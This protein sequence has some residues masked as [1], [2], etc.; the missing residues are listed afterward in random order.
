MRRTLRRI[1]LAAGVLLVV[2]LALLPRLVSPLV[3]RRLEAAIERSLDADA[4]VGGIALRWFGPQELRAARLT[5]WGGE[6]I[7]EAT[8]RAETS[9][10]RILLGS[11]DLGE[12]AVR[13]SVVVRRD[14]DG[15][16][17]LAPLPKAGDGRSAGGPAR[18]PAGLAGSVDAEIGVT[19]IDA[20]L[21]RTGTVRAEVS[22][23]GSEVAG[24]VTA[25]ED[26]GSSLEVEGS[27]GGWMG[28]DGLLA[29]ER[30]S[31]T[32][33][34]IAAGGEAS[35]RLALGVEG[36][37]ISLREPASITVGHSALAA[38]LGIDS[39]SPISIAV[40]ALTVSRGAWGLDL[41]GVELRARAEVAGAAASRA[42]TAL[43]ILDL[44]A[45]V[46]VGEGAALLQAGARVAVDGMDGG[47]A[48]IEVASGR[49]LDGRGRPIA[50][51]QGTATA[52]ITGI[53][54]RVLDRFLRPHGLVP[55]EDIGPA[56]SVTAGAGF[57]GTD[58]VDVTGLLR[59]ENLRVE[60]GATL[61]G[62]RLS[63]EGVALDVRVRSVRPALKRHLADRQ[64]E[65]REGGSV[66][67]TVA[68][69]EAELAGLL[70]GDLGGARARLDAKL[71]GSVGTIATSGAVR[72]WR[73]SP[74][75]ISVDATDPAAGIHAAASVQGRVD[76]ELIGRV[77]A[78][79]R[80]FD[81]FDAEGRVGVPGTVRGT[82]LALG[83]DVEVVRTLL[84]EAGSAIPTGLGP[85]LDVTLSAATEAATG[86][87]RTLVDLAIEGGN[88]RAG[89]SVSLVP[90]TIRTDGLWL[91][92]DREVVAALAA[93]AG[94]PR[95]LGVGEASTVRVDVRECSIPLDRHRRPLPLHARV[96]AEAMLAD[97]RVAGREGDGIEVPSLVLALSS[98]PR[99]EPAVSLRGRAS[100]A[101]TTAEVRG[102]I[103]L[104]G[105]ID[106]SRAAH[107]IDLAAV[108][109]AGEVV[110]VGVTPAMVEAVVPLREL[111]GALEGPIEVRLSSEHLDGEEL[112]VELTLESPRSRASASG[113]VRGASYELERARV[114]AAVTPAMA[115]ALAGVELVRSA[116]IVAEVARL[117]VPRGGEGVEGPGEWA[118]RLDSLRIG[119][120]V[121]GGGP[122]LV[123]GLAE[124]LGGAA[125]GVRAYSAEVELSLS[126]EA[127]SALVRAKGELA[128]T[129]GDLGPFTLDATLPLKGGAGRA[130]LVAPALAMARLDSL[131]M[132]DGMLVDAVGESANVRVGASLRGAT[133][134]EA[135]IEVES[136][137]VE[138]V[139]PVGVEV[140]EDRMR[141]SRGARVRW[142]V[143]PRWANE[144]I[145][146]RALVPEGG[147]GI[148]TMSLAEPA[149]IEA[150]VERL[151]L[152]RGEEPLAPEIFEIGAEVQS[153]VIAF[154]F[155]RET[156][157]RIERARIRVS[158]A[159]GDD[160]L[161]IA[162]TGVTREE[163]AGEGR[164]AVDATLRGLADGEGVP[165]PA[166]I[167]ADGKAE[168]RAVP[169]RIIDALAGQEGLLVEAL[170]PAADV[171]ASYLDLSRTEG[172][173]EASA[174]SQ[175][176]ALGIAGRVR[177]G[178]FLAD[179]ET[180]ATLQE[181]T[182]VL[183]D[184]LLGGLGLFGRLEKRREDGPAIVTVAGLGVPIDGDL[185]NLHGD[186]MI[187][188]GIARFE[189]NPILGSILRATA[190]R[191]EGMVGRRLPPLTLR[192][193]GG[194]I[195]FEDYTLP[196]GEYS[197]TVGGTVDVARNT[198]DIVTRIP[199][200]RLSDAAAGDLDL[201]LGRT[202][203][204]ALPILNDLTM[205]PFR[206]RG[207]IGRATP[208][209]DLELL[210]AD[211]K[212]GLTTPGRA[213]LD[214]IF[215]Q[216]R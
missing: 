26:G 62:G 209:P 181:V 203:G 191:S 199:L 32:L 192:V 194:A 147:R 21:R 60:G 48:T 178:K 179:G 193:V 142:T 120:R 205:I 163:E 46:E 123:A 77:E 45:Q 59:S 134:V 29:P 5:G 202:L 136:P 81:L 137:L 132:R 28:A 216:T 41:R 151:V 164:V 206:T 47:L 111:D 198:M 129:R 108:R 51:P 109:P 133:P 76:G 155:A 183:S 14:G 118:P 37:V 152:S 63:R 150:I 186:F 89:G 69:L 16:W 130:T 177:A 36:G 119:A 106:R 145:I 31:G 153:P 44:R 96:E 115:R 161:A 95:G 54:S 98:G 94:S 15:G 210:A 61:A 167:L 100:H 38:R 4:H 85:K 1:G 49:W 182:P 34:V 78:D 170:G 66:Q 171:R 212:A 173:I 140:L 110:A 2:A 131:L 79:L 53:E 174:V 42:G 75:A 92:G 18:L 86:S 80:A 168:F 190:Q 114:E 188:A 149:T 58:R 23:D 27:V 35:G 102:E 169:T 93:L 24:K 184:R 117:V 90:G 214:R 10:L 122:V 107:A 180:K 87:P 125:V 197:I 71:G 8:V 11:R 112:R 30:A 39:H 40:D 138:T 101:G 73:T 189:A 187:S 126:G 91:E 20:G 64:F 211:L 6:P 43:G 50:A 3:A 213:I 162:V 154:E 104:H 105:L 12:I 13:G 144:R 200:G 55:A 113:W 25:E 201:G 121:V 159:P 19:V 103:V 207:E 196:L 82:A 135:S 175:R 88:L 7:G 74:V 33:E 99:L 116:P 156:K 146:G 68:D 17:N 124:S 83:I 208:V 215:G 204:W 72:E 65:V 57:T 166:S 67:L 160:R 176:A 172:W 52:S 143:S 139:G 56:V 195:R 9:L 157:A 141:L 97:V 70:A 127:G 84:G 128:S 148:A 158:S 185:S 22:L 165:T